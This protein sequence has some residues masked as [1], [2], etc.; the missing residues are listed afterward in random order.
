MMLF[1]SHNKRRLIGRQRAGGLY[2]CVCEGGGGR[3]LRDR[4]GGTVPRGMALGIFYFSF[5][6]L[7]EYTET[8]R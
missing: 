5:R 3:L 2:S 7:E 4:G 6:A 8:N 1:L